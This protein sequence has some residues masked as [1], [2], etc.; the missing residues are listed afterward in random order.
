VCLAALTLGTCAYSAIA[1][2]KQDPAGSGKKTKL[3]FTVSKETTYVTE[4]LDKD[5]YVDYIAALNERLRKGVTPDT[6]AVALL[7]Q[8]LGPRPE[9]GKL[10]PEF[11]QWLGIPEPPEQGDYYVSRY[12][13]MKDRLGFDQQQQ[14]DEVNDQVDVAHRRPWTAKHYPHVAGWL[15]ANDKPLAAVHQAVQRSHY[16][17]PLVP[18]RGGNSPPSLIGAL[19]PHV[20]QCRDL[21][22]ALAARGTL[23]AGEGRYDEAWQDLLDCHR[24]ARHLAHG[25]CLI[26]HLVGY[27]LEAIACEADLVL[28]DRTKLDAKKVMTYLDD[29][30]KLPPMPPLANA[31]DLCER[32]AYLETVMI[33]N[34]HGLKY[35]GSLE[36]DLGGKG[37]PPAFKQLEDAID[38]DPALRAAN[39]W[40][41]RLVAGMRVKDR[42]EREKQLAQVVKELKDVKAAL[43]NTDDMVKAFAGPG[44]SPQTRGKLMGDILISLMVP[45]VERVQQASDRAEQLQRN[46]R[47]AFAL[48][49]YQ[50]DNGKYPAKLADLTPKYLASVPEDLF[51]GKALVYR[52]AADGY[53]LYSFGVNGQ[54]DQ[55]R[56]Y[57]DDPPGDD[58]RVRMPL[59]PWPVK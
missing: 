58:P 57:R 27:A 55:G 34:R 13:F 56:Y 29:L 6:N 53:L 31:V 1:Q 21:G 38:W 37:L 32:F 33:V 19:I 28:L 45:G 12:R 54:D 17:S 46:N 14:F 59:P 5:G 39:K 48:A 18:A 41:D 10:P 44:A 25:G 24:L 11:Y 51:T 22:S 52:P 35:L 16:Y 15:K 30:Q 49:A 23:R 26:E 2:D 36:G 8:T 20:Q 40:Y 3:R 50:R 4:P 42:A 47:V 7:C 43:G 9:G